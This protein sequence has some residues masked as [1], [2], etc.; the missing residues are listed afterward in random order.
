M[1][2][3][4]RILACR[5]WDLL[6]IFFVGVLGTAVVLFSQHVEHAQNR[7]ISNEIRRV[8]DQMSANYEKSDRARMRNVERLEHGQ[9]KLMIEIMKNRKLDEEIIRATTQANKEGR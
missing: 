5:G 7:A 9:Q 2:H 4:G 8:V 3:R 6:F 1:I